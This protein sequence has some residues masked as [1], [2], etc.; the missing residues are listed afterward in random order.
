MGKDKKITLGRNRTWVSSVMLWHISPL[1][2]ITPGADI[3]CNFVI[4]PNQVMSLLVNVLKNI[5][6][7]HIVPTS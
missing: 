2:D 6:V 1:S 4:L 3:T 7:C 5:V